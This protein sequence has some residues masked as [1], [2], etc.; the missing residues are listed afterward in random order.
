MCATVAVRNGNKTK[1]ER[2]ICALVV[3]WSTVHAQLARAAGV[4]VVAGAEENA[5]T[6]APRF[7]QHQAVPA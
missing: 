5:T 2:S 1:S 3:I 4:P 6:P 7:V